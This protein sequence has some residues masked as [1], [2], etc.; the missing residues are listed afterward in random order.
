MLCEMA[1]LPDSRDE[2][3]WRSIVKDGH[4]AVRVDA[5]ERGERC[6]LYEVVWVGNVGGKAQY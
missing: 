5:N 6:G 1:E 2:G 3:L 4:W